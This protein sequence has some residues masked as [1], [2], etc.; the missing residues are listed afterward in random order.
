[1]HLFFSF[2]DI[3]ELSLIKAQKV[4]MSKQ[5]QNGHIK[6]N[7]ATP[8]ASTQLFFSR[9]LFNFAA[10]HSKK[11]GLNKNWIRSANTTA[12]AA[13]RGGLLYP[14]TLY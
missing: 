4:T 6:K 8:A 9:V 2:F 13:A 3:K 11:T 7:C 14:K 5:D 12:R 1:M 10:E